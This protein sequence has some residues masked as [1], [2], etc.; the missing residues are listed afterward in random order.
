MIPCGPRGILAAA[1]PL[2]SPAHPTGYLAQCLAQWMLGH[3]R[4]LREKVRLLWVN[5]TT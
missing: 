5:L 2:V 1:G 4:T 3:Y